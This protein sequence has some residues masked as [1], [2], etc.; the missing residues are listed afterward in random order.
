M[1][2]HDDEW[3]SSLKEL[4]RMQAAEMKAKY[5]RKKS[6]FTES[7]TK[8]T[9]LREDIRSNQDL[10]ELKAGET[11]R[12]A[13]A[14][15]H[16]IDRLVTTLTISCRAEIYSMCSMIC[17]SC[18]LMGIVCLS[19]SAKS[20]SQRRP[21]LLAILGLRERRRVHTNIACSPPPLVSTACQL[22]RCCE[23]VLLPNR[24]SLCAVLWC[25][26]RE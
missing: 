26:F 10:T 14:Q 4:L 5:E 19:F 6:E 18:N 24:P 12:A 1:L 9:D 11:E 3:R 25:S 13:A 17:K 8:I 22:L 7:T 2:V 21:R 15:R 20:C 16:E 23:Q